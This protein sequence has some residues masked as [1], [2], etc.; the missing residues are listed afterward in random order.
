MCIH[1][2]NKVEC[3]HA[4][5]KILKERLAQGTI[6]PVNKE[7]L[8]SLFFLYFLPDVA[9]TTYFLL[10]ELCPRI[11]RKLCT[12]II[13]LSY[14]SICTYLG[15]DGCKYADGKAL[16]PKVLRVQRTPLCPLTFSR[17]WW[18]GFCFFADSPKDYSSFLFPF[19]T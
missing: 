3:F 8:T 10:M 6:Q 12:C 15:V 13:F 11:S 9:F 1:F 2:R 16:R 4:N 18:G 5:S 7:S 17:L 19:G 14:S